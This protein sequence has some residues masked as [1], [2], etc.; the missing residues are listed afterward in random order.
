[1]NAITEQRLC[2]A[3]SEPKV[4]E[5]VSEELL[6]RISKLLPQTYILVGFQMPQL[7]DLTVVGTKLCSELLESFPTLTYGEVALC[8]ELGVKG[9]YGDFMGLN[10]R[11]YIRWLKAYKQS[12]FRYRQVVDREKRQQT[13]L[14]PVSEAYNREREDRM[15][16]NVFRHY[17]ANYP[18][19]QLMPGRVY[20]VLQERGLIR[21]SPAEKKEAMARFEHWKPSG[22]LPMDEDTR[23]HFV[24]TEAMTALLK[25]YFDKL[26]ALNVQKL[27][28]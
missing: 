19:D 17:C 20:R 25:R 21:D 12:D 4:S 3:L 7:N 28:L 13:A 11:T 23:L 9:E 22:T 14:P 6:E 1:M 5:M 18:L 10:I 26:I 16:Q 15:L 24:K 8:F 2:T 27:P